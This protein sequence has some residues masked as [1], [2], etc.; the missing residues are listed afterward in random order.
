MVFLQV[1]DDRI[2]IM[3]RIEK[4]GNIAESLDKIDR[5]GKWGKWTFDEL[6]RLGSGE[7]DISINKTKKRY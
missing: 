6:R 1:N 4:S 2:M 3:R 7:H 5:G